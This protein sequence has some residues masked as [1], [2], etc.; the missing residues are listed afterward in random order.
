MTTIDRP[1]QPPGVTQPGHAPGAV[2]GPPQCRD[3]ALWCI[4][5]FALRALAAWIDPLAPAWGLRLFVALTAAMVLLLVGLAAFDAATGKLRNRTLIRPDKVPAWLRPGGP[6]TLVLSIIGV[7][8][9]LVVMLGLLDGSL[10][11]SDHAASATIAVYLA[12]GLRVQWA[13]ATGR[14]P[15]RVAVVPPSVWTR[16]AATAATVL[17]VVA[18]VAV[19]AS[20]PAIVRRDQVAAACRRN[21]NAHLE[22]Q[23]LLGSG[24]SE[25][26]LQEVAARLAKEVTICPSD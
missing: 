17:I 7:L 13:A 4:A 6:A 11:L 10:S 20:T 1:V 12:L 14:M 2:F 19:V 23:R 15:T 8:Y 22:M 24:L 21:A 9:A 26:E 5:M 16:R 25:R 3:L 18:V